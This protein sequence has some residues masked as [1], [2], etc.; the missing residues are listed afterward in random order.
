[1]SIDGIVTVSIPKELAFGGG[2]FSIPLPADV[3]NDGTGD[4]VVL[5]LSDG[6]AL[7]D[8]LSYDPAKRAIEVHQMPP[9]SLPIKVVVIAGGKRTVVTI[10]E[11]LQGLSRL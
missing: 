6:S 1:V 7:P 11:K 4:K 2:F 8:W 10:T 9:D 5:T 3:V